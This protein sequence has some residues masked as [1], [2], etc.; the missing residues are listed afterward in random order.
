MSDD[1]LEQDEAAP[2]EAASG[3]RSTAR[4]TLAKRLADVVCLPTS[5]VTPQERHITGDLLLEMLRGA[6]PELRRRIAR[7]ISGLSDAPSALVRYLGRDSIDVS[8]PLLVECDSLRDSDL[9]AIAVSGS[10]EHRR[11]IASRREVSELVGNSLVEYAEPDVIEALLKNSGAALA[12]ETIECMVAASREHLQFCRLL[13]RRQELRPSQALTLYWWSDTDSRRAILR[14]FA[15]DRSVLQEVASDV[16]AMAAAESW[17][18][19]VVRKALQFIERRQR[20]RA[21]LDKCSYDSVEALV[22]TAARIGLDAELAEE[23]SYLCGVKPACGAKIL[24]DPG[25]EPIAVLCKSVGLKRDGMAL[26]WRALRRPAEEGD[27]AW[28]NAIET[29]DS[30]SNE[31][32]QTVL[33]YWNWSLTSAFSPALADAYETEA[34]DIDAYSA[35]QKSA[36]LVFGRTI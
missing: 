27:E 21:A 25:G 36:R 26:L 11:L 20:N 10:A 7:R 30:L 12:T 1:A 15:V 31:K 18:D 14:R 9:V 22:E 17:A 32:S 4:A 8:H 3:V 6:D 5:R 28:A 19:D 13:V 33:R 35:A 24:S 34:D 23:L 29:Y 2:E 16:F